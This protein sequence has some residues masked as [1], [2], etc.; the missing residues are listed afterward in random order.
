MSWT[1]LT[2]REKKDHA[3]K[4]MRWAMTTQ[5]NHIID[6]PLDRDISEL[7]FSTRRIA[8]DLEV[9]LSIV[10]NFL[11]W[12]QDKDHLEWFVRVVVN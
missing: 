10:V 7:V 5:R 8:S 1:D 3:R 4:V 2:K 11:Q 9:P 6:T 12:M